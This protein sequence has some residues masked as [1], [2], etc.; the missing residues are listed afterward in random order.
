MTLAPPLPAPIDGLPKGR[1]LV[2]F[3]GGNPCGD[4][5]VD[6]CHNRHV[7]VI[8]LVGAGEILCLD[9]GILRDAAFLR[10]PEREAMNEPGSCTVRILRTDGEPYDAGD[11]ARACRFVIAPII[12]N[13]DGTLEFSLGDAPPILAPIVVGT[14]TSSGKRI[15]LGQ[16]TDLIEVQSSASMPWDFPSELVGKR[17]TITPN[18]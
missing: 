9:A 1:Y 8:D 3:A 11:G 6:A 7:T 14:H 15:G 18:A 17:V 10:L 5:L 12:P 2:Y 16:M 4:L 13:T